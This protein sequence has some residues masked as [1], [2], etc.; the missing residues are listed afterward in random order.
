MTEW[1]FGIRRCICGD[2]CLGWMGL[3]G[4]HGLAA[5]FDMGVDDLYICVGLNMKPEYSSGL[6]NCGGGR[7]TMT[8]IDWTLNI[9][10]EQPWFL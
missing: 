10:N 5:E 8:R 6:R 1:G 9:L 4:N 3:E 2:V 7:S